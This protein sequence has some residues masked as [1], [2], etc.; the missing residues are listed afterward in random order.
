MAIGTGPF[1]LSTWNRKV[2]RDYT[3]NPNYFVAG[4]PHLDGYKVVIMSDPAAAIAAMRTGE[5]DVTGSV[6]ETLLPTILS[7]NPEMIVRNQLAI[8]PDQIMFSLIPADDAEKAIPYDPAGAKKLLADAGFPN[9]LDVTMLTTDGYGPQFVTVQHQQ[10]CLEARAVWRLALSRT[11][12]L[13]RIVKIRLVN[14][15]ATAVSAVLAL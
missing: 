7:T 15:L 12:H 11:G 3:K 9:G 5:L 1:I 10:C 13:R 14:E 8:G 4:K 6:N 2:E